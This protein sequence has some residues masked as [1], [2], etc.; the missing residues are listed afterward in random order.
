MIYVALT[1]LHT[2]HKQNKRDVHCV[3]IIRMTDIKKT[4]CTILEF[5]LYLQT[6]RH[7]FIVLSSPLYCHDLQFHPVPFPWKNL[8]VMLKHSLKRTYLRLSLLQVLNK[9]LKSRVL[10]QISSTPL[11]RLPPFLLADK[12]LLHY[13]TVI[14]PPRWFSLAFFAPLVWTDAAPLLLTPVLSDPP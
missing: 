13:L 9:T 4:V 8:S 2:M 3:P 7:F 11:L 10:F 12:L 1:V 6:V 14:L 5:Y